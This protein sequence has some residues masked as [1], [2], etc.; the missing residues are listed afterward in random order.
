[1]VGE[2]A[3]GAKEMFETIPS[4]KMR[5]SR[6]FISLVRLTDPHRFEMKSVFLGSL[7]RRVSKDS[8][9]STGTHGHRRD[10]YAE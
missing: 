2:K 8:L 4:R 9:L 10:V 5:S 3:S 6:T 7:I 1:M